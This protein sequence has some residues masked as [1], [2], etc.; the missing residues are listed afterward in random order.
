MPTHTPI[1]GTFPDEHELVE[2]IAHARFRS[3]SIAWSKA[4][5]PG[6]MMRVAHARSA[7]VRAIDVFDVERCDRCSRTPLRYQARSRRSRSS[8]HAPSA[9]RECAAPGAEVDQ[10][11]ARSCSRDRSCSGRPSARA[12]RRRV[13]SSFVG[14]V[15]EI[16]RHRRFV[17]RPAG[18]CVASASSRRHLA[19][20]N[21]AREMRAALVVAELLRQPVAFVEA[22]ETRFVVLVRRTSASRTGRPAPASHLP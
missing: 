12:A 2:H 10:R 1:T 14:H 20:Q 15:F 21:Q 17:V 7:G 4:P 18:R 6:R 5:T 16:L 3:R 11:H 19:G 9:H 8:N 22:R 13:R